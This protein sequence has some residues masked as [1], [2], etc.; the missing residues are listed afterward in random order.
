MKQELNCLNIRINL[1]YRRVNAMW[2]NQLMKYRTF[3]LKSLNSRT[4]KRIFCVTK[5]KNNGISK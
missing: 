3:L 2:F 4:I 5:E 1:F